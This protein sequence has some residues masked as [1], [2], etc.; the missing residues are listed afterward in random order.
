MNISVIDSWNF[1]F[2][3][4]IVDYWRGEG[5]DVLTNMNWGPDRTPADTRVC[6]FPVVDNNL[7]QASRKQAPSPDRFVIA[8][9]VDIDIYAGNLNGV[10]WEYVDALVFMASHMKEYGLHRA[11]KKIPSDLP[12][13]VVPGG[14]DLDVWTYRRNSS[15]RFNIAWIGRKWIAKN[16]FGAI[17]IFNQ[18][19]KTD[20]GNPW[21]LYLRADPAHFKQPWW[22]GH[23][24]SYIEAN[25]RLDGRIEWVP[26][27]SDLNEWLE[28]MSYILQT[29]FK[30]AFGYVVAQAAAKGVCPII[31][32][33]NGASDIWPSPWVFQT[34]D[35]AIGMFLNSYEPETYRLYIGDMYPLSRRCKMLDEI[36]GL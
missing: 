15:R 2:S 26:F 31:Q 6:Y 27:Q 11:G 5:H 25:R 13:Y 12:I 36:C 7:R 34:H 32:M 1:K 4:P 9:A 35:E 28:G 24:M 29:S 8:E 21:K 22:G 33:T 16:V 3:Q 30:E 20:P 23:V 10:Q 18:L 17:Q 19:V 14:V